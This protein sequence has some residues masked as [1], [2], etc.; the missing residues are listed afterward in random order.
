MVSVARRENGNVQKLEVRS[1]LELAQAK[2]PVEAVSAAALRGML[3]GNTVSG[4]V[5]SMK[6]AERNMYFA[7][8]NKEFT[9]MPSEVIKDHGTYRISDDGKVCA[10]WSYL[11]GGHESCERW[12]KGSKGYLVFDAFE[13]LKIAGDV[14]SGNPEKLGG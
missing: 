8:D 5:P 9:H 12:F 2:E 4:R 14:R 1:D 10:T 11:Q 3:P 6:N 13:V 7:A